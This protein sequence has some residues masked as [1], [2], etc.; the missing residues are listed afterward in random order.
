MRR[1]GVR[2]PLILGMAVIAALT[3]A[4]C[5]DGDPTPTPPPKSNP[6]A[7]T[8]AF[9]QRA[10]DYY[11]DNGR[12]KTVDFYNSPESVDG[13]WY[14]FIGAEND[15]VVAHATIPDLL[16]KLPDAVR[17]PDGYPT[18]R[19][20]AA[21]ATEDGAWV[22]Y[23][24]LN[25]AADSVDTKHSW[26]IRHDGLLFG[27]GWYE[28]GPSKSDPTAYTQ[29]F[30]RQALRLYDALGRGETVDFYNSMDSVDGPWYVAIYDEDTNTIAHPLRKDFLGTSPR[31]RSDINGKP[32]GLEVIAATEE[33]RW[34]DYVF[35]NPTS[36]ET[37]QKHTWVIK[38]DG[39]LF[40]S[41]WYEPAS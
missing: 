23:S 19:Q 17:G 2:L 36:G 9:V 4:A 15:V 33:G 10:I 32:Y 29:A 8:Q 30:V 25:P 20:I 1:I 39:L 12:A 40:L 22:D 35:V 31:D 13:P 16:G 7:Y 24:Y 26:V 5:G 3:I 38:Y 34:V 28:T 41:G 27:S 11:D 6:A 37:E 21:A 18:G 14:V